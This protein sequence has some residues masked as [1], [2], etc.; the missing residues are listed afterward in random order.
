MTKLLS[1][2]TLLCAFVGL[3]AAQNA[4]VVKSDTAI[5][6]A[7]ETVRGLGSTIAKADYE[8]ISSE[9][10][11][12]IDLRRVM[13]RSDG[14]EVSAYVARAKDGKRGGLPVIV[15]NRGGY[16]EA[17]P[18]P[19]VLAA[20]YRFAKAGF[21]VIAPMLRG[22]DGVPGK[23]EMGG[24]DFADL[25]TAVNNVRSF[26][27]DPANIF[28]AGESRGGIMTYMAVRAKLPI[29]AAAVW[30]AITDM[31]E[32]LAKSDPEG[33]L[34]HA[35]WP[36]FDEHKQAILQSRSAL[37]GASEITVPILVMHGGADRSVDPTHSLR[38]A[39]EL[40]R[41]GRQYELHV[42]AGDNHVLKASQVERDREVVAWFLRHIGPE[43]P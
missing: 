9:I 37:A 32:F 7:F 17:Q 38:M 42:F 11:A 40:Q 28:M 2:I 10:K 12:Q 19:F 1:V 35:V 18:L 26:G 13:Y 14:H 4:L 41:L 5:I 36:D 8:N 39:A 30:G 33:K 24:A 15:I 22:S 34:A 43:N 21:L 29:R 16:M 23:D 3:S 20:M 27:G 6:P 25:A 31:G